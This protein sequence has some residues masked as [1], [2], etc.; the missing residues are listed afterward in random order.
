MPG[1]K[2]AEFHAHNSFT[3]RYNPITGA[4]TDTIIMAQPA[5]NNNLIGYDTFNKPD[6]DH[7]LYIENALS[8]LTDPNEWYLDPESHIIY[9]M[10]PSGQDPNNMYLV[11]AKLETLLLVGG[12]YDQPVHDLTF[13]G[14][15]YM[16][17]TWSKSPSPR[18]YA[19]QADRVRPPINRLCRPADRW[20]YW[21]EQV[22]H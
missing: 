19:R 22:L 14:F 21:Y 4:S 12:T 7:G 15:N 5:W 17:T 16:H 20:L 18:S 1:L 8:L 6:I 9:Y 10:P 3:S 13:R 11:L 2:H